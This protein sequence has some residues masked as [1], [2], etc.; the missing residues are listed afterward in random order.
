MSGEF[1]LLVKTMTLIEN[2]L[3]KHPAFKTVV[4]H[5]NDNLCPR[6]EAAPLYREDSKYCQ[7]CDIADAEYERERKED[8]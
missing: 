4:E 3:D 6:C 8:R 2:A 5:V 7:E 1:D